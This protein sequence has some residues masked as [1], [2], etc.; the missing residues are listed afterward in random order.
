MNIIWVNKTREDLAQEFSGIGVE[1]GVEQ[2]VFSEIICQN[3]NVQKLY[4]IDAWKSHR[5]YRDHTHQQKLD[6]FYELSKIRLSPYDCELVRKFSSEAASDF[7]DKVLDFVY[8]DANHDYE[9]VTE[10]IEMW[11]KKV[12]SGGI[13]S[14]HDY[15]RRK[16]QD[17][18]YAVVQ[19][20]NDFVKANKIEELFIYRGEQPASWKFIKP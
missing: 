18:Y 5:E 7:M 16:G 4:S 19:A 15:I 14:G 13:I 8:I 17:K 12:K 20:V 3:K 11:L 1:I 2:G 10:D 6:K 9:H